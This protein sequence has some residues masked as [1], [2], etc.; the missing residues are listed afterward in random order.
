MTSPATSYELR[1][2]GHLDDHWATW[3][4]DVTLARHED[5]TTTLTCRVADQAHLHGVLA[6][7]RDLGATLLS[8]QVRSSGLTTD[9]VTSRASAPK[10]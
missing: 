2:A 9:S 10:P 7:I 4:G 3:L 1:V 6:A 8:L 5:G